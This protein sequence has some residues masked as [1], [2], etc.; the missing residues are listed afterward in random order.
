M[1]SVLLAATGNHYDPFLACGPNTEE[2]TSCSALG[3]TS[4]STPS[5]TYPC[6]STDFSSGQYGYCEVG[7]IS[8]KFGT[9][10]SSDASFNNYYADNTDP[11]PALIP[12]YDDAGELS[13][14]WVSLVVHCGSSRILCAKFL[15]IDD[16]AA[17]GTYD[18]SSDDDDDT[19]LDFL[20]LS[21]TEGALLWTGI[22][23]V[24]V[25]IG[26]FVGYKMLGGKR[27]ENRLLD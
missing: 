25:F 5:Y 12:A 19:D 17:C 1:E 23:V 13:Q 15:P 8:G 2:T 26:I 10:F 6:S 22:V 21:K 7:D 3:R 14:Q 9:L 20:D 4:T 24:C 11:V 16:D 27:N 18:Q